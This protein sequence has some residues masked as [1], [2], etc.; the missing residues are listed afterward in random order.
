MEVGSNLLVVDGMNLAFRWKHQG[1]TDFAEDYIRTI[2]SLKRSYKAKWVV[3]LTDYGGSAYRR[4]VYGEYKQ[5]RKDKHATQTPEEAEAF[6]QFLMDY[7]MCLTELRIQD[8]Y[9]VL[10][11]KGVEADDMSA[12]ISHLVTTGKLPA[13]EHIWNISSDADWDLL[14]SEQV[15]RFS[16][17]SR[18]EFTVDNWNTHYECTP[19][20]F[21][22][23]KCLMGDAGDN[24]PGVPKVGPKRALELVRTY[25]GALDVAASL[26]IASN[27]QYIKNLN[28]FGSKQILTNYQLMDLVTFCQEAIG[29]DNVAEI[30]SILTSYIK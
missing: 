2:D 4:S 5:N 20:E 12:L 1:A 13:V 11:Y 16:Y 30:T 18:K 9:I 25:G 29:D 15:S 28:E 7:A 10:Q 27:L 22:S 26:P 19:E 8:K 21:I 14:C 24:V 17:V 23:I 6:E 3:V